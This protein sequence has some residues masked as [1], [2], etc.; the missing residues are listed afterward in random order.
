[1]QFGGGEMGDEGLDQHG[2]FTLANEW[3]GGSHNGFCTRYSHTPEEDVG[4]LDDGPLKD[5]PVVEELHKGNEENDGWDDT[6]DES[7]EIRWGCVSQENGTIPGVAEKINSKGSNEVEDIIA[8]F[9]SE[10]E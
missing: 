5:T 3:R 6:Q 10:N 8:G 4:K 2:R 1:M 7:I 9:C